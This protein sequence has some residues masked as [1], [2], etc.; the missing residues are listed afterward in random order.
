MLNHKFEEMNNKLL[1]ANLSNKEIAE[2]IGCTTSYIGMLTNKSLSN[3][4]LTP[5]LEKLENS[6]KILLEFIVNNNKVN[7]KFISNIYRAE[8]SY[9]SKY[10][11]SWIEENFKGL[12]K[13]NLEA[14]SKKIKDKKSLPKL[15]GI[16]LASV[17]IEF[18]SLIITDIKVPGEF[19]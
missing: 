5:N 11:N 2:K 15:I 19:L 16:S 10:D 18:T 12:A 14:K 7:K 6:K 3:N 1:F 17:L 4:K 8:F 13:I 9:I